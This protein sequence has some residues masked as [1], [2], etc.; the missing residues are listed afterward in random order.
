VRQQFLEWAPGIDP[1]FIETFREG[2]DLERFR[3]EPRDRD[4]ARRE[5]RLEPDVTAVACVARLMPSKGQDNLLLAAAE[6]L[7][8]HPKTQ[9]LLAG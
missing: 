2:V 4:A 9:F 5:W 7:K 6:I 3:P 8:K 1:A